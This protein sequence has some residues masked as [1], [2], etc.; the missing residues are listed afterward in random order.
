MVRQSRER[1]EGVTVARQKNNTLRAYEQIPYALI[2]EEVDDFASFINEMSEIIEFY[3]IYH[4]GAFFQP[5]G[6]NGDYVAA[7]LR[8]KMAAS[9]INKEARFLFAEPPTITVNPKGDV[10]QLSN[11][12]KDAITTLNDLVKTILDKNKF[13][14]KL[15][16]GAKDCF[17]GKR[18]AI[19]VNWNAE[20]GVTISFLPATKFVYETRLG[21]DNILE[22]FVAFVTL[23][24]SLSLSDRRVFR[25]RY[26][27]EDGVVYLEEEIFDGA[28]NSVEEVTTRMQLDIDFIP[29]VVLL[30]DGLVDDLD[31]ESEIDGQEDYEA[32]FSKLSNADIDSGRK[33]MNAITYTA[34]MDNASTANLKR[35]PGAHWDLGT[36]QNL[37]SAKPSVGIIESSMNYSEPLK[38]TLDR[39]KSTAYEQL[40]IPN[41]TLE[42]LQGAITSG[43][44]LKAIYWPLIIRC[45]EKMKMWGPQISSLVNM[46][47]QGCYIY[48]EITSLYTDATMPHI[49][50]EVDVEQNLPLPEDEAEQ[51]AIM[52]S[53]VAGNVISRRKYL[54]DNYSL[55]DE[56]ALDE[57]K[58][59]ALENE[60]LNASAALTPP[61]D[62][63][64]VQSNAEDEVDEDEINPE[65]EPLE[66]E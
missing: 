13:E 18:L 15:L 32:W 49:Q 4:E 22:K 1:Q 44:G 38:N 51:K 59:M 41:V 40:D 64:D 53:E 5:E 27:L 12:T 63:S 54:K 30:N 60:L 31:G 29:A 6:T 46:I 35:A 36:D 14:D 42:S 61:V 37:A 45:K 2:K 58:Q 7:G 33:N 55:T 48:E 26:T 21:N 10:G 23:K 25:K 50:Y 19:M 3:K 65:D 8:Y 20:D 9:L 34:D 17:I 62:R 16:K 11:E 47:I 57:L 66:E 56:E 39:I 43:K 28:G 24:E 52:L